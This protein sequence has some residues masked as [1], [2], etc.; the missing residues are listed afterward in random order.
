MAVIKQIKTDSSNVYDL[1]VYNTNVIRS[2]SMNTSGSVNV[3]DRAFINSTRANRTA[4]LPANGILIEYTSNG[5]STWTTSS[6]SDAQKRSLFAETRGY[7]CPVGPGS[8]TVTTNYWTRITATPV[9]RYAGVDTFYV[10]LSTSG[11]NL[12]C[13]IERST[14]GSPDT[15]TTVR[16]DVPVSGWSGPNEIAFSY[17]SFGGGTTQTSNNYKYRFT[18]KVTK[19]STSHPTDAPIIIDLRL[20]GPNVWTNGSNYAATDHVYSWDYDQN[21]TFPKKVTASSFAGDGQALSDVV[22]ARV[23]NNANASVYKVANGPLYRYMIC[24][25]SSAT[26]MT[27]ACVVNNDTSATKN[28]NTSA[29]L[30]LGGKIGY[31]I[32]TSMISNGGSIPTNDLFWRREGTHLEYSFNTG[33]SLVLGDIYV[34]LTPQANG[35]VRLASNNCIT[36]ALPTSDDGLLYLLLGHAYN[37]TNIELYETHPIY[38]FK[39]NALR[40][41]TNADT[42][43]GAYVDGDDVLHMF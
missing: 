4:F 7:N 6:A 20:Y 42:S 31:Y 2:N 5:G 17:G 27:P 1:A 18:F 24:F 9:D 43:T 32:N 38:F 19:A 33:S 30:L 23:R 8:G 11:H 35:Y 34:K 12:S 26:E 37:T 36:Q 40:I 21:V 22:G 29:N 41:W 28:L 15:F 25:Q 3:V 16:A 14:I 10:W 39:N 13:T